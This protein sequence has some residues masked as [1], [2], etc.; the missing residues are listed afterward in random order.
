MRGSVIRQM[1]SL[2]KRKGR[3]VS[4]KCRLF[5]E[6]SSLGIRGII[7][8]GTTALPFSSGR[9]TGRFTLYHHQPAT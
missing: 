7:K 8:A 2:R 3:A 1:K 4:R 5:E 6:K 9:D